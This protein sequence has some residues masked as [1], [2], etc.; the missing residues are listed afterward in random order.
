MRDI[1]VRMAEVLQTVQDDIEAARTGRYSP[2]TRRDRA[3]GSCVSAEDKAPGVVRSV[4]IEEYLN[5]RA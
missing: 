3:A 2:P 4:S 1:S 5:G